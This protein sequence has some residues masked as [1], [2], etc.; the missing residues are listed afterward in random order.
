MGGASYLL[1]KQDTYYFRQ[2]C[3]QFL[4]SKIGQR[5]IVRS[6][7]VKEKSIATRIAREFKVMENSQQSPQIQNRKWN[8]Q[9]F[10]YAG[11]RPELQVEG[12]SL[13]SHRV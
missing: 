7:G 8:R 4:K 2:A 6:L 13:D 12:N 9:L 5:E 1:K 10:G 11:A 3:S